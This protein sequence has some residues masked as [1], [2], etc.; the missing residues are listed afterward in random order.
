MLALSHTCRYFLYRSPADMRYGIHS[1]A[2]LVRNE[3][4]FDPIVE[5]YLFSLAS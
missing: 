1:L 2:G 4:G 3:L 5:M